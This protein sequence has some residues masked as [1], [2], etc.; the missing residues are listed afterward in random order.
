MLVVLDQILHREV[1]ISPDRL[2]LPLDKADSTPIAISL[3]VMIAAVGIALT[4]R[5][6]LPQ[7]AELNRLPDITAYLIAI[8]EVGCMDVV[9][10]TVIAIPLL[11]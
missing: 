7:L 9:S 2:I 3:L 5:D 6:L 10:R 4:T 11:H 8:E 1:R